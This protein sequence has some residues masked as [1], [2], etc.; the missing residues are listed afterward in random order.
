LTGKKAWKGSFKG[1]KNFPSPWEFPSRR[2]DDALLVD[3]G[4]VGL[5]D[6]ADNG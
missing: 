4:K 3:Q 2:G 5:V 1:E 6:N